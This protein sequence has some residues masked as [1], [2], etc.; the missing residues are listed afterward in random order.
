MAASAR[1]SPRSRRSWRAGIARRCPGASPSAF[2]PRPRASSGAC[3]SPARAAATPMSPSISPVLVASFTGGAVS[4][5]AAHQHS[6]RPALSARADRRARGCARLRHLSDDQRPHRRHRRS[7]PAHAD[8]YRQSGD[9][10]RDGASR[11]AECAARRAI[12]QRP[13]RRPAGCALSFLLDTRWGSCPYLAENVRTV[14]GVAPEEIATNAAPLLRRIDAAD[15]ERM[16]ESF[17]RSAAQMTLL[18][19]EFREHH[20]SKGV[21][22]LRRR[23]SRCGRRMAPSSGTAMRRTSPSVSA[24]RRAA[25]G[26]TRAGAAHRRARARQ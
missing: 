24:R 5:A 15:S 13:L 6:G 25:R 11:G 17:A 22:W 18:R 4:A 2:S 12:R 20:L 10:P 23:R 7:L 8:P 9:A 19:E 1:S 26:R 3:S 21:I 14:F 16:R